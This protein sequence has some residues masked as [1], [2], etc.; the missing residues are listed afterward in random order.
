V[1][2]DELGNVRYVTMLPMIESSTRYLRTWVD[3]N[4]LLLPFD[5]EITTDM[6]GET[7]QRVKRVGQLGGLRNKPNAF[8]ILDA[9]RAMAQRYHADAIEELLEEPEQEAVL[10]RA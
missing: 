5:P 4:F 1:E 9:M 7:Q 3:T 8:H 6:Q 10:D 2:T